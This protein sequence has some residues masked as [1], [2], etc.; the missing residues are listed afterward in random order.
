[1][2][3]LLLLAALALL[4]PLLAA[5]GQ[6]ARRVDTLR[7]PQQQGDSTLQLRFPFVISGS[8]TLRLDSTTLETPRDFT[9]E[10]RSGT[11]VLSSAIRQLL[12]ADTAARR[13]VVASY[14]YLPLGIPPEYALQRLVA[15]T[16]S[17]AVR[18]D[19]AEPSSGSGSLTGSDI[20]G[21]NFQ[22]SGSVIRGLTVGSNRDLTV[23]SGLR[24]QFSGPIADSVIVT[25]AVTDEQTPIQPEG[26][27]QTLREVDNIFI[28]VRSPIAGATLG[29]FVA[30]S[31]GSEYLAYSRKLQGVKGNIR[32][33]QF[34]TSEVVAAVAPGRFL[35]QTL[36]GRERD[37]GPYRLTG[38]NG[39]QNIVVVA[40]TERVFVDGVEMVR[41]ESNDYVIDYS[42]GEVFF[43][44]RRPITSQ[45][46]ITVDF[47]LADRRYSRSF[48]ALNHT[49]PLFNSALTLG[50]GFLREADNQDAPIDLLL[51]DA[52]RQLLANA[53]GDPLLAIRSG[54]RLVGRSDTTFG[55]Y[56]RIDTT[57]AGV[58]DSIFIYAPTDPRAV[59]NVSF[60][61]PASGVGDY[62][63][64]AFGEYRFVGKNAGR[65]MPVVFLPLPELRQVVGVNASARPAAGITIA[66]ELA[67]SDGSVNRFSNL[68]S[69]ERR[70]AAFKGFLSLLRDSIRVGGLSVGSIRA[71]ASARYLQNEFRAVE[72]LGEVEFGNQWNT[73][74]RLGEGGTDDFVAEGALHWQP[75]RQL[76][77]G[78]SAGWLSRGGLFTSLRQQYSA[79]LRGDTTLP[80]A[81]YTAELIGTRDTVGGG[82]TVSNW[83][84]QRGGISYAVGRFTPGFR[85]LAEN[86]D[87][88]NKAVGDSLLPA[89]FRFFE[90]GP[91][92][93]VELPFMSGMA[94]VRF[95]NE[96]SARI[97]TAT[98][99]HQ[100]RA[101][102]TAA[103]WS[104]R[105][106][107]R[108]VKNLNSSA[109]FTYRTRSYKDIPGVPTRLNSVTVLGRSQTR[110]SGFN[111][112]VDLEALY[113][114]QTEQA[115][116]LQY[117][118]IRVPFGQ[119]EYVWID[120]DS[121]GVQTEN[122]FRLTNASDGEYARR[123]LQT[124][125]LF[126][127]IDLR[128]SLRL[129]LASKSLLDPKEG[130]GS[131]LAPLTAETV[132]RLEEKS[133]TE[134][135]SDIYLLR[136]STF[137][138]DST[139][140]M[141]NG[142]I[143]Q[144]INLFENNADYSFRLRWSQREGMTKLFN[145]TERSGSTE[146][147]LRARWQPTFDVGLQ[148]DLAGNRSFL[149]T[150]ETA[151][152]RAFDAT[153]LSAASDLSYRPTN[154]LE[155]GWRLKVATNE[156]RLPATPRSTTVSTN[157]LRCIYSI[158]T[159]GR[160][161]AEL[162]RTVA[163]GQNISAGDIYSLPYQLTD[164][165]VIGTT[166]VG[167]ATFEYRISGNI[168]L[169]VTYTGRAQPPSNRVLHLGQAEV[170][171]FF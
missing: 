139:T 119:G 32:A 163:T 74:A 51:D 97:D 88:R 44:T 123:T 39:E 21:K 70:G 150:T 57:I 4:M 56:Y 136:L 18:R 19:V 33:G 49:V 64:V 5:V 111:R 154:N 28:E 76:E 115:A 144:D 7:L 140:A 80:G 164:G 78:G 9:I 26:N 77:L 121:N 169:S 50:V 13:A 162:E 158:E 171:A 25:G 105:G 86:R 37:Q 137:Q 46:R 130:I 95:R 66:G 99:Q 3:R 30:T 148:L 127:V 81:D 2:F 129:R 63:S 96:D 55:S 125:Q 8:V 69:A 122:E 31:N 147:S 71:N 156:D 92:L 87:D 157:E 153:T 106:E 43:Q 17:A 117:L 67:L 131:W 135:E 72:R 34:G 165:Y 141:G 107:L 124:E 151:S 20:F 16:D 1:M 102:G 40:G 47:E 170:R 85:F 23:Q 145:A 24:L 45:S 166:W 101:D 27:T 100:L 168:Q 6:G 132:L 128:T 35:T 54:V 108:G 142:T 61:I 118:Y 91:E 22:R 59:F 133:Q 58:P 68:A 98:R 75:L 167:R 42:T 38:T 65:Y 60:S 104:L 134:K 152:T 90:F 53:G 48:L 161:R 11:I 15:R 93:R 73:G 114:V 10:E 41:G 116:R 14:R 109:D 103:T 83:L 12:A 94:S 146:R 160:L 113:E 138:N 110:W 126:P 84:R 29:K 159:S 79:Q 143:Q 149:R 36:Q 155:V 52:D 120:L 89:S 112:G 62:Q 82:N